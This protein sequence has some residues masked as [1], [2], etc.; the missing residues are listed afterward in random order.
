VLVQYNKHEFPRGGYAPFPV[1]MSRP[2]DRVTD[3]SSP[4][5]FI[6][7]DNPVFHSPNEIGPEDF[8]GWVTERGLYFLGEWDE[9]RMTPL[10]ELTDPG[11]EPKRGALVV[12]PLGQG[13]WIYTGLSFFRQ[14]PAGVP[15]AYRLFANL[16]SLDAREWRAWEAG[17]AVGGGR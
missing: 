11:E 6:H 8:E 12:A 5:R 3:E 2:H 14:L 1:E 15:G 17:A 9:Q 4:W 10:L 13:L 16:I 7:P